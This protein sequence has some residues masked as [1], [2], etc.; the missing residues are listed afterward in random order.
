MA[1]QLFGSSVL[2]KPKKQSTISSSST[3]AEIIALS[4]FFY[5]EFLFYACINKKFYKFIFIFYKNFINF[6]KSI[7]NL[8]AEIKEP[9]NCQ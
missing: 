6:I 3:E 4:L 2:W 7:Y 1:I 8:I 5:N 9:V